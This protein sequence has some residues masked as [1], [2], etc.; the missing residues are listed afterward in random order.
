MPE[1]PAVAGDM[2]AEAYRYPAYARL[3][4]GTQVIIRPIA[5][6]DAEREQAFV[7]GLS[8]ESRY[9]RFM[10][11]LSELSPQLLE[12][13]THPDAQREIALVALNGAQ[14]TDLSEQIAVARC[15]L[16]DADGPGEF[17]IV[18]AD[19]FQARGLGHLLMRELVD[20]ARARGWPRIEGLVLWNNTDMLELM[21]TLGFVITPSPDDAHLRVATLVL[22][23]NAAGISHDQ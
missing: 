7:R 16:V 18:V 19:R 21:R 12:R 11:T 10:N 14:E 23:G 5:P 8:P 2:P 20:C 17:A 22:N 15:V 4:D 13:F 1:L 6:Q 3:R 9:F